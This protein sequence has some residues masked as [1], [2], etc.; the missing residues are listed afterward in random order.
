MATRGVAM[1]HWPQKDLDGHDRMEEAVAPRSRASRMTSR[2]DGI[3]VELGGPVGWATLERLGQLGN[4]A[5]VSWGWH[6]RGQG[7]QSGV[8]GAGI[9]HILLL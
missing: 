5:G 6:L 4:H 1:E 2:L 7:V 8:V 3:G 9:L